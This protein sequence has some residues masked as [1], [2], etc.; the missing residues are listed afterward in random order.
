MLDQ[1]IAWHIPGSVESVQHWRRLAA[2]EVAVH[3]I[4]LRMGCGDLEGVEGVL[5]PDER[6]RAA[7]FCFAG[8]RE[9]FVLARSFL[10]VVLSRYGAGRPKEIR[11]SYGPKGKPA[12]VSGA[13]L[14]FNLS[15]SG[16][17]A[18]VAVARGSAVGIDVERIRPNPNGC[19]IASRFFSPREAEALR[20]VP[21]AETSAAFYRCWTRK[22][23]YVKARG[24][25]LSLPLDSFEVSLEMRGF[26]LLLA[27]RPDPEE[28]RRWW[29]MDLNVG[30][31]YAAALAIERRV[32]CVRC[33]GISAERPARVQVRQ[34]APSGAA[35]GCAE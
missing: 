5:S 28:A 17:V 33:V 10:R 9:R 3:R 21:A 26:S 25:G 14:E 11:L 13:G 32:K 35:R 20:R 15:H 6:E 23:A 19:T 2:G 22:E 4:D 1:V 18:L 24:E 29:V 7:R 12:L 8:Q 31:G 16:D 30:S 27:T 34:R